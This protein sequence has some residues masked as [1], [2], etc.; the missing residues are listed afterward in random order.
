MLQ[1]LL[2]DR[3]QLKVH[4]EMGDLPAYALTVGKN[5][6]KFNHSAP[7][8]ELVKAADGSMHEVHAAK[9]I[10]RI[11]MPDGSSRI[12]LNF[13]R[14]SM[15]DIVELLGQSLD[16]PVLDRTGLKGDY[17]VVIEYD[18]EPRPR[19]IPP[20][21]MLPGA[22]ASAL[23]AALQEVGL[24]L[25]STKAPVEVLVIDHVERPSEN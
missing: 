25:E 9:G 6:P 8:S 23:S 5:G 10:R 20:T 17:D 2:E 7:G 13:R 22:T 12:Q 14:G 24:R 3:F 16:L 15:E 19:G 21:G 11:P 1:V 18:E 4:R